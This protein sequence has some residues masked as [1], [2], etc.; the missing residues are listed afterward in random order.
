[1][2]TG[3]LAVAAKAAEPQDVV[4]NYAN[5]AEAMYDDSLVSANELEAA[6]TAFLASPSEGSFEA[7]KDAWLAARVPYQQTEVYRFGNAYV[8]DWEGKVNAWPLDEGMIDYVEGGVYGDFSDE[9]LFYTANI[10]ANPTVQAGGQEIDAGTID[11]DLIQSLHEIDE[12]EANVATGYHV[13]EFLLWGQDL[14]GT[15]PGNGD[16]PWTD[17]S[18]EECTHGNCDRR[19]QYLEVATDLLT[20]DLEDIVAAWSEGGEAREAVVSDPQAG[21]RALVTGL[22]SLSYGELAGER[23][24][25]GLLLHDPE[26]EHDCFADNTHNSHYYN[27]VGMR[28]V[29]DGRYNRL[30]GTVI[31]GPGLLALL[32]PIDGELSQILDEKLAATLAAATVMKETADNGTM[33]YDQM[34]AADN[35]EGNEIL[36][37]VI[38]ALVDQTRTVEEVVSALDLGAIELEGSDSLD[39]PRAV[40]Q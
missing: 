4:E 15:G 40:F 24:K 7:A 21:I 20:D 3:L 34:L 32:A 37:D 14:N 13:I 12:V 29:A 18:L 8:D 31:E 33:A 35:P 30:D 36:E 6:I 2:A 16:R 1:M 9:N 19:R 11:K 25:L 22:G 17:Y 28:N 38:E 10:V 39:D 27:V 26:E 23:M 5:I